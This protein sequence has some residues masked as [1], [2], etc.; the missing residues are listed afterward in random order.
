MDG[1]YRRTVR[2]APVPAPDV[3]D[4]SHELERLE[5]AFDTAN[6]GDGTVILLEGPAGIG[7][8]ALLKVARERA[9]MNGLATHNAVASALDRDFPFG[10]VHQL[11]GP[12]LATAGDEER[13]TL[14]GGA[15]GTAAAVLSPTADPDLP[16]DPGFAVLHGLYWLTANLAEQ[17]PLALLVDDLHWADRASLRWLEYLGRRLDGVPVVVIATLRPQEP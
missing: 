4:R 6:R 15:A 3:L 5:A 13:D 14:L 7:K 9:R 2:L 17:Q 11:L 10:L 12:V 1:T 8:T 16:P